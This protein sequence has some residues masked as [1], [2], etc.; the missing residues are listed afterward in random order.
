M[1]MMISDKPIDM[2]AKNETD[3]KNKKAGLERAKMLKKEALRMQ[4]TKK[5]KEETLKKVEETEEEWNSS[6]HVVKT[7]N[8]LFI[9]NSVCFRNSLNSSSKMKSSCSQIVTSLVNNNIC[10]T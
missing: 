8:I 10:E 6:D 2:G 1:M 5:I 3:T 9:T 7:N 4:K